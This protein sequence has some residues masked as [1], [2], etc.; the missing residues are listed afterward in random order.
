MEFVI[1]TLVSAGVLYVASKMIDGVEV[2]GAVPALISAV[3]VGLVNG[4][5]WFVFGAILAPLLI[6]TVGLIALVVNAV[7]LK[8]TASVVRGFEISSFRAALMAAVA[9]AL[10]NLLLGFLIGR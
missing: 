8:F 7:A 10:M 2:D 3:V 1:H 4:L 6:L 9:I 5:I